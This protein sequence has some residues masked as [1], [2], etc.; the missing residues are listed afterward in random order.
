MTRE[1]IMNLGFEELE[2]RAAAIAAETAEAD[3]DQLE[4][5]N[6]EL[7]AIEERKKSLKTEVEERKKAAEAVAAGAGKEVRKGKEVETMTNKEIRNTPQYIEAFAKYIKTGKDAEC[8]ALLTENA[9]DGVVP[10]P[11][12]VESRVR[13]AWEND[14]IF[15]R[16]SKTFVRGNL[17]VGFEISA[18]DAA[19]H[20]E[21]DDAPAEEELVLGIV[22]MVPEYIKKWIAPSDKVLAMG[23]EEFLAYIYDELTYKIIKKGADLVVTVITSA[24]ASSTSS[25]VGVAQIESEVD[26]AAIIDAIAELGDEAQDNV[27][28]ASGSTIAAVKKAALTA[29]YALDP[30]QGLEVIQKDGVTGAIVGDLSGVQANLPEG[31]SVRFIFDEYSLAEADLV[32]I[33]GKLLAAIAVVGPKMFAYIT[34]SAESES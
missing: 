29:N 1:E 28:I 6:A 34:G 11:E 33:V 30:F 4:A 25:A 18:T 14:K 12:L 23:A 7:D 24:P 3:A 19:V 13:Q 32:K 16:V 31:D 2:T 5:L 26:A 22:N 8:R 9:D 15:S 21:G 20:A 17:K 27:I 10:V